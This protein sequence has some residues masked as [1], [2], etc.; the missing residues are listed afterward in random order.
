MAR[1]WVVM[2]RC[3]HWQLR[4]ILSA[5]ASRNG[6]AAR[7]GAENADNTRVPTGSAHLIR[8]SMPSADANGNRRIGKRPINHPA[9]LRVKHC[10][11]DEMR[12]L[13]VEQ[14]NERPRGVGR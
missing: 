5:V 14:S 13:R 6:G 4:P 2:Q 10:F 11:N 1:V 7:S 8:P 9:L 3:C 12:I